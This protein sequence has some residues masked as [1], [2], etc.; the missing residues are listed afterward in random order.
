MTGISETLY[1]QHTK[2]ILK[3]PKFSS[4]TKLVNIEYPEINRGYQAER[5]FDPEI[6][7][8]YFFLKIKPTDI[9]DSKKFKSYIRSIDYNFIGNMKT[10]L[11]IEDNIRMCDNLNSKLKSL[12]NKKINFVYWLNKI[13]KTNMFNVEFIIN[14]NGE[15]SSDSLKNLIIENI[16]FKFG[17]HSIEI[18]HVLNEE[19]EMK[20]LL[21]YKNLINIINS[22]DI[23]SILECEKEIKLIDDFEMNKLFKIYKKN[24][25]KI[26]VIEKSMQYIT[27]EIINKI[28]FK[29]QNT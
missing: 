17:G 11:S 8:Y 15:M 26:R 3:S 27:S 23:S 14:F 28:N 20:N 10:K 13:D 4:W 2:D 24:I 5:F 29:L 7:N 21:K 6:L 12:Y 19:Y 16:S 9:T 22:N 1:K 25:S 18:N